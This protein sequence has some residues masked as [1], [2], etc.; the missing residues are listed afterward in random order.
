[1]TGEAEVRAVPDEVTLDLEIET[2]D[3]T[4]ID[5]ARAKN[6]R[7]LADVLA[8][9]HR[10]GIEDQFV[11]TDRL[12][13]S[14]HY[15]YGKSSMEE[16]AGYF[17]TRN[18]E[19]T[20]RDLSKFENL[21]VEALKMGV[22]SLGQ[23]EFRTTQMRKYRDEARA[24]AI[25]AAKEKAVA[26]AAE[27]GVTIGRPITIEESPMWDQPWFGSA[28]TAMQNS[29]TDASSSGSASTAVAPGQIALNARI[30]VVFELE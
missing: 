6:D 26:L 1:V 29:I 3:A 17:T 19:V 14:P 22:T 16:L 5:K 9:L 27:L 24:Q 11:Q 21:V 23:A 20:L 4:D 30:R 12:S 8:M 18:V 7:R 13:I 28:R 2:S 10:L 15:R 25:R